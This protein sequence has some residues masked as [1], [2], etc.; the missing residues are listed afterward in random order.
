MKNSLTISV[1][2]I[3]LVSTAATSAQA[4]MG[5]FG[6][7]PINYM[8]AEVNDPVAE[9]SA[10][11]ES[12]ELKLEYDEKLGYLKSVLRALDV[13]VTS[14]TLVFSKTSLQLSRISPRRPRAVYF[15]D[16]VYVGFCQ[17]GDVLE[18]ASTDAQQG[19]IFYTLK[20]TSEEPPKIVRDR[21]V[22]LSCH[23]SSRTQDVPGYLVRSVFADFSGRP[24]YG[25]GTFTTDHTSPFKERWGGWYVTGKHGDM[26]HMGNVIFKESEGELDREAGANLESL[27]S[28]VSTDSY[29]SGHSD[30]VAL[31]VME[32]QTQMH[33]AI[34]AA[35][36]ETRRAIYQSNQMNELLDR[37]PGHLSES[38]ERRLNKSAERVLSY[39]LMCDEFPLECQDFWDE[40][41]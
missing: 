32:H 25:N 26:Q 38:A 24:V 40:W 22:C 4:Q 27:D 8:T 1:G 10:K 18:F 35:N 13:P 39:L 7:P 29:L 20:Q 17:Q 3:F 14:Q 6:G 31:M 9:L 19:A 5:S 15:N 41:L 11:L 37:E 12:G 28:I 23:S 21:G 33:N 36:Y 2:L 34:A 30:I 16:D